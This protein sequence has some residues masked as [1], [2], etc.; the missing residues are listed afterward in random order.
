MGEERERERERERDEERKRKKERDILHLVVIEAK[1]N[2]QLKKKIRGERATQHIHSR[3]HACSN[4]TS[5]CFIH[6]R[7]NCSNRK[8]FSRSCSLGRFSV[9][10]SRSTTKVRE[11]ISQAAAPGVFFLLCSRRR[12]R[13]LRR[14]RGARCCKKK[15]K[16]TMG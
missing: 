11:M 4:T 6:H 2:T 7:Q 8:S 9:A 13:C 3:T 5:R 16:P 12:R 10:S 15:P 1:F 14:R